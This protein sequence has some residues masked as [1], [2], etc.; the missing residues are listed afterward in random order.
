MDTNRATL[1]ALYEKAFSANAESNPAAVMEPILAEN[2]ISK[3]STDLKT[4][5]QLIGQMGFFHK[6]IPNLKWEPQQILNE[7]N[8]YVVRSIASGTPNGDFMGLPTDGSKS[9]RIMSIDIHRFE[10]GKIEEVHHI[11]DWAT[12]MKQLKG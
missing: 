8:F 6:L 2:F 12:A 3:G 11:E 9:F 7:G 4:K 5:E 1:M 10:N